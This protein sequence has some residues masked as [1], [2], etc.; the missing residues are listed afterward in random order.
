MYLYW[1][2]RRSAVGHKGHTPRIKVLKND[3]IS[4]NTHVIPYFLTQVGW[5]LLVAQYRVTMFAGTDAPGVDHLAD[6][7]TSIS[8]LAGLGS[9]DEHL[10]GGLDK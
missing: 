5:L 3:N 7:D 8:H 2:K 1:T 9:L 4:I 6:E 10:D